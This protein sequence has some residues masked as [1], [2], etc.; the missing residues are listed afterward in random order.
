MVLITKSP[1]MYTSGL[2]GSQRLISAQRHVVPFYLVSRCCTRLY[3]ISV[4]VHYL[5]R[6]RLLIMQ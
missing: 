4:A 1:F 6:C 3:A 5:L 2:L